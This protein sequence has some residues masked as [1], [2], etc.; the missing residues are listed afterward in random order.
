ML[1]RPPGCCPL[2]RAGWLIP[3]GLC[4]SYSSGL[5]HA[6][7]LIMLAAPLVALTKSNLRLGWGVVA[8]LSALTLAFQA[9]TLWNGTGYAI[10]GLVFSGILFG[11]GL[12]VA[13]AGRLQGGFARAAITLVLVSMLVAPGIW[14]ALT[15]FKSSPNMALPNAGPRDCCVG[16][17]QLRGGGYG[18]PV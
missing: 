5:M 18:R 4:F 2:P 12:A 1:M 3:A 10:P 15:T 17:I 9:L 6:Y 13:A 8:G 16:W 11:G 7:Y 14:S